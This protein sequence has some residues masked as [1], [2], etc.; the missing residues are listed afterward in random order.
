M[1]DQVQVEQL[2]DTEARP[3]ARDRPPMM[4]RS[5]DLGARD[6]IAHES[7][8]RAL[9]TPQD[10]S[11]LLAPVRGGLEQVE[12][13]MKSVDADV[14]APLANAFLELIGQ[15]GK[16][17][18]PA[19][20]LLAAGL[21]DGTPDLNSSRSNADGV[22]TASG[23]YRNT[24]TLIAL[25]AA[26][27]MLH[28]AT[29]VHDDV[30]DGALLRRDAPTLNASWSA[31]ATVLAGDY[32]FARSAQFAA[33]TDNVRVITIFS[34]TLRVIVDGEMRQLS[35]RNDFRQDRQA[36]YQRIYAKTASLYSAATEAAA[37]LV[38]LAP[39]R[40]QALKSFGYQ[41]GMAFQIVDD[42]L[43]FVGTDATLGKPVG[44]DLRQGTLTLP[45]LYYLRELPQPQKVVSRLLQARERADTGDPSILSATVE[46]IV[47]AVRASGAIE[48]AHQEALG[49]LD[50]A[51]HDLA[52]FN[53]NHYQRSLLGLCAFV[54]QRSS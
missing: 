33:E 47:Q 52:P 42:I 8:R 12:E 29:L 44:S 1:V 22:P 46:E 35:D 11:A 3:L 37:V 10:A 49:F 15:G 9:L 24:H 43:D 48:A 21:Q 20:A 40:V 26:V 16:R 39:D 7:F 38:G 6:G 4:P 23:E 54:V 14:F 53:D 30:I 18:R 32:M 41:F 25:A 36:Y 27:E 5:G 2:T 31:G 28:T 19:L 34:D 45:F 51:V 13:K 50:H 17:L